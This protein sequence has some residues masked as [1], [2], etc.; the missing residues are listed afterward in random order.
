MRKG[1]ARGLITGKK[2]SGG[3]PTETDPLEPSNVVKLNDLK[4]GDKLVFKGKD[5]IVFEKTIGEIIIGNHPLAGGDTLV[6]YGQ[7]I[8]GEPGQIIGRGEHIGTI[9]H[10]KFW[11]QGDPNDEII[12][13]IKAPSVSTGGKGKRTKRNKKRSKRTKRIRK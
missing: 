13:V 7:R 5:N 2:S 8:S 11:R 1:Q 3:G 9:Q 12:S 6:I 4:A 10:G